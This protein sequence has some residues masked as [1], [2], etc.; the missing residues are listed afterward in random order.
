MWISLNMLQ[1]YMYAQTV[2]DTLSSFF[3]RLLAAGIA[4]LDA[5]PRGVERHFCSSSFYTIAA[6][7]DA[8]REARHY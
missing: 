5:C 1:T 2:V 4:F 6:L 7:I 3:D 8:E